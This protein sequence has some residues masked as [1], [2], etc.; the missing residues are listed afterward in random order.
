MSSVHG[1]VIG[2]EKI[3]AFLL[4]ETI[5]DVPLVPVYNWKGIKTLFA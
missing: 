5:M 2:T 1:T 3:F 4:F